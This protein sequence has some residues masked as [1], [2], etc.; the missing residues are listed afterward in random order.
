MKPILTCMTL[1]CNILSHLCGESTFTLNKKLS[2]IFT[3]NKKV[4]FFCLCVFLLR[5]SPRIHLIRN[6]TLKWE[7]QNSPSEF[8]SLWITLK[9]PADQPSFHWRSKGAFQEVGTN[10]IFASVVVLH[11][12]SFH[13]SGL[14]LQA[15]ITAHINI[16]KRKQT[17]TAKDKNPLKLYD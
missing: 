6:L 4:F 12:V 9:H 13:T 2:I 1:F 7:N 11:S 3:I 14:K 8:K 15:C 5:H 10:L 17:C 16:C